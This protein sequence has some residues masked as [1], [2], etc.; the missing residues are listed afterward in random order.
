MPENTAKAYREELKRLD[1]MIASKQKKLANENF[2]S[3]APAEVVE[4]ERES[5]RDLESPR[6]GW[7]RWTWSAA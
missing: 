2:V 7:N 6:R 4:K 5:L 1:G 3:R